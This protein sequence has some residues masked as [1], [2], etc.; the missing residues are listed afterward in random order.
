MKKRRTLVGAIFSV[1]V[2]SLAMA[3]MASA[4]SSNFH[5]HLSGDQEVD[6][7]DTHATGQALFKLGKSG[8]EMRFKLIVANIEDVVAAHIHC[9]AAGE[10]GPVG[11]TL[12]GGGPVSVNGI[13]SQGTIDGPDPGNGCGWTSL[14]EVVAA[15][16]S[17]DTYVNVHTVA[18]PGGEIRGQVR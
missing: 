7:V 14:E 5:A 6:A 10:N 4:A 9:A 2:F 18:N 12:F 11:V 16:E 17:G 13:L 8:D 1:L 15:L 3:G